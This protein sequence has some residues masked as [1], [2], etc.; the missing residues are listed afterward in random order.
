MTA[1]QAQDADGGCLLRDD[2]EEDCRRHNLRQRSGRDK[3]GPLNRQL[4]G[5]FHLCDPTRRKHLRSVRLA[6]QFHF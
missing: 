3:R 4:H 6:F 1:S 2:L 5:H